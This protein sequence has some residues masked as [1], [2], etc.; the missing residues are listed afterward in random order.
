MA[1]SNPDRQD[2]SIDPE[3]WVVVYYVRPHRSEFPT[4]DQLAFDF[5]DL[6][7]PG[8]KAPSAEK[9]PHEDRNLENHPQ[10]RAKLDGWT[11]YLPRYLGKLGTISSDVFILDPFAGSGRVR[12]GLGWADGSP[13]IACRQAI[14]AHIVFAKRGRDVRF[15]LRFVEPDKVARETL[16]RLVQP[17][18]PGLDI[19][20]LDGKASGQLPQLMI[21]SSAYPTI[22]FFD[23]D[24]FVGITFNEIGVFGARPYNEILLNFDVQ[25]LLRTAGIVQTRSVSAFCGGDWW[26]SYRH[27]GTFDED[28]FLAEYGR[29]LAKAFNYVSA[30]RLDFP[31][32]HANRAIVQGCYSVK[33]V[34][35]WKR[36]IQAAIPKHAS[37]TFDFV[38]RMERSETVNAVIARLPGFAGTPCFYGAIRNGLGTLAVTEDDVH[39]ALLFLKAKGYA[40][41]SSTLNAKSAPKPRIA[42]LEFPSGLQWDDVD[43]PHEQPVI[44]RLASSIR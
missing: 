18:R 8:P 24:G 42:I 16:R 22:A 27:N 37:I 43:R 3:R 33:G 7:T 31:A 32:V 17:F 20:V 30:Q 11:G 10:T 35:L 40:S 28:G 12:D 4:K 29:R 5:D 36:S 25:G 9:A 19:A 1:D 38:P 14:A 34:D 39:Q 2:S 41:W 23:P 13:I 44:G 6:P 26:Q 15:H 21:E